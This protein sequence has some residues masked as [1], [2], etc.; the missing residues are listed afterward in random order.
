VVRL[1]F[2]K[3]FNAHIRWGDQ[4]V[5]GIPV[6]VDGQS[7]EITG[8]VSTSRHCHLGDSIDTIS[9]HFSMFARRAEP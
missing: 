1:T 3:P 7:E 6:P 9:A 4:G 2:R 5:N 8:V